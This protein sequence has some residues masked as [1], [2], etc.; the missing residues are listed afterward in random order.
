MLEYLRLAWEAIR[1]NKMRSFLTMLGMII[2]IGSVIAIVSIGDTMRSVVADQ[3]SS[4]GV[5]RNIV[6]VGWSEEDPNRDS[7]YYT[8]D[9]METIKEVFG[10]S[11][12]YIVPNG[13]ETMD[14]SYKRNSM[15]V[16]MTPVDA[17]YASVQPTDLVYGRM[18]NEA[19]V[20]SQRNN[21]VVDT[22]TAQKLFGTENAVGKIIRGKMLGSVDDYTIVGVY[23]IKESALSGLMGMGASDRGSGFIPYT[24]MFSRDGMF[25]AIDFYTKEGI[26]VEQFKQQFIAYEAKVKSRPESM[27]VYSSAKEEMGMMDQVMGGMSAAVGAIAAISLLVGGIG[28][29][30]IM[31]VSV[32]ERTREIG[33]RKAL[34]ARTKEVM[35]Q[36]LTESA[37]ISAAG[38]IIGIIFGVGIVSLGTMLMGVSAV[39]K[40]SVILVAVAFSAVV[41][42]F[43]GLYPAMKAAKADPIEALRYE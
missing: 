14:T 6:Y 26:N 23:R 15:K 30:N 42:I 12:D 33:I 21:I 22:K 39:V 10:D 13:G 5:N 3:Y 27:I 18:I 16:D 8:I 20:R 41:G 1:A 28:I 43:F 17:G 29:M 19:D 7:D 2:G 31:M 11:I 24:K 36:F 25:F 37:M 4:V 38:G 34:G 40:P 32:T 9:E 35:M